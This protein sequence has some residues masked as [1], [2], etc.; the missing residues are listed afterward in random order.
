MDAELRSLIDPYDYYAAMNRGSRAERLFHPAR[1]RLVQQFV[2][3]QPS[4]VLEVGSGSGCIAL[5]LAQGGHRVTA[6]ELGREHLERLVATSAEL[7]CSV[8]PVQA[9]ARRLPFA[10]DRFDVVVVASLVHLIPNPGPVLREAE[11]VCKRDGLIVVAGPW[12]LHPKS[13]TWVKTLLRGEPPK[14]KTYPFSVKRLAPMLRRSVLLGRKV[15]YPMG[16][17]ATA[18]RPERKEGA[19]GPRP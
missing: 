6:V 4:E 11:R 16:Y 19:E 7:G 18:W 9:D 17:L 5:P 3:A 15:D 10:D 12:R 13:M 1:L 2:P 8:V 14:D